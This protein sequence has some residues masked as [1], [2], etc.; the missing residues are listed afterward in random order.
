MVLN[1]WYAYSLGN[2]LRDKTIEQP[3][4]PRN[5]RHAVWALFSVMYLI[6]GFVKLCYLTILQ[7]FNTYFVLL[8][9]TFLF[10]SISTSYSVAV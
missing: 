6:S 2:L 9:N 5:Y 7:H 1:F 8:C 4:M 10:V 3:V